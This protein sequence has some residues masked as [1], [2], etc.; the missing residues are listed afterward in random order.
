MTHTTTPKSRLRL[1]PDPPGDL[2]IRSCHPP[3]PPL[4]IL[5]APRNRGVGRGARLATLLLIGLAL[6]LPAED[7]EI[8]FPPGSGIFDVVKDGGLD[9]SGKTDVTARLQA[10]LDERSRA[11]QVVYFPRGTYLVSAMVHCLIKRTGDSQ[12]PWLV[13]QSRSG[14]VIR[15]KDGL[16]PKPVFDLQAKDKK[17]K[18][19]KDIQQQVVL[20]TGESG[21][22]TFNKIVRNLTVHTG[23]GNAGAIGVVYNTSNCGYLGEVDIVSGDGQGVAGLA[24][25]GDESGPGQVRNVRIAGFAIGMYG[26][27]GYVTAAS[28][29]S[30]EGARTAGLLNSG[31]T[32]GEAFAIRMA[33]PGPAIINDGV[34]ALLGATL[35]GPA[36]K[37]PAMVNRDEGLYYLRDCNATGFDGVLEAGTS[38][39]GE[40][41]SGVATG[42][43]HDSKAALKLPIKKAPLVP[44]EQDLAKW[45]NPMDCG[46]VGD[47]VAD[48]T[49]AVAKAL[50]WPGKTH[51]VFPFG[52]KF[53]VKKP[54]TLGSDLVRVVGTKGYIGS[55]KEDEVTFQI[56][57]GTPPV[58]VVEGFYKIPPIVVRTGRTVVLDSVNPGL[59]V[60]KH[61][62]KDV[63]A[64]YKVVTGHH[65]SGSG[66]VFVNND[67]RSFVVDNPRQ[68]V[69]LRHYN[70][71]EGQRVDNIPV[72]VRAGQVWMLGWKSENLAPRVL[73]GKDGIFELTGFNNYTVGAKRD[74]S[75]PM[76]QIID[77]QFSCALLV[78]RGQVNTVLVQETRGGVA[79]TLTVDNNPGKDDCGLYTGYDPALVGR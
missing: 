15:L 66:D 18:R 27:S 43:F 8:V 2:L 25:A 39:L 50:T 41:Q 10:I 37:G 51:A 16:W 56:G 33:G 24:V 68:R 69:W 38:T 79:R 3:A 21:N 59:E 48:D 76:F 49:E 35:A 58:V 63:S 14:T 70:C 74:A 73:V 17:G 4:P 44:W 52:R 9:N 13:G 6:R 40:R 54:L 29:V 26:A 78:Q 42:L 55:Q 62:S 57:D 22:T 12:G 77:G 53:L 75:R 65:F 7:L 64:L 32:A 28:D 46:A 20:H 47:G 30:I 5:I 19:I 23:S 67:P 1:P 11:I 60:P 61:S 34:L 71:E 72:Q 45:A 36:S 31:Y